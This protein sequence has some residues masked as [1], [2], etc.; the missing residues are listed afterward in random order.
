MMDVAGALEGAEEQK[1]K[2]KS[3]FS[4]HYNIWV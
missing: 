3:V 4:F 2:A 1:M